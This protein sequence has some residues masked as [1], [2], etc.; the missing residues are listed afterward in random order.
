MIHHISAESLTVDRVR[1]ILENN[2]KIDLSED[3]KKRIVRC[4]EYLDNK[5]ETQKEIGRAHV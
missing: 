4:R 1:E 5:M 3:A 2:I